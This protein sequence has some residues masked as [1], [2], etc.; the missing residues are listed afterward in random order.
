MYFFPILFHECCQAALEALRQV[1]LSAM[2]SE[3]QVVDRSKC[4]HVDDVDIVLLA[5]PVDTVFCLYRRPE[6][7]VVIICFLS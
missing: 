4:D 2:A 5:D 6:I 3:Y 1:L 7:K